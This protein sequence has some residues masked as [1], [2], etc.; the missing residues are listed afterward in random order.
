MLTISTAGHSN[1][2]LTE[3]VQL[4]QAHGMAQ[5]V[6]V[7]RFPSSRRHP[8]FARAMLQRELPAA[9]LAYHWLEDLGGMRRGRPDSPHTAWPDPS[10]AAYADHMDTERFRRAAAQLLTLAA[11]RPTAVLCAE[12]RPE[13]CHRQLIA[14]WLLAQG[15]QVVHLLS[16]DSSRRHRLPSFAR[17]EEGRV[18]YDGP[19]RLP[20]F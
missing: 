5:V 8:H 14:D 16:V 3:L 18:I 10:L 11:E 7:R 9:G 2:G 20:G 4:L 17:L 19:P 1:R 6:D 12:A 15:H 13:Q